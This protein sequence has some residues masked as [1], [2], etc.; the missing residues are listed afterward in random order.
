MT[1]NYCQPGNCLRCRLAHQA[2]RHP[3]Q[4]AAK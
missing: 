3:C 1:M 2:L 4:T